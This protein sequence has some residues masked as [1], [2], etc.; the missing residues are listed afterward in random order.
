MRVYDAL[1]GQLGRDW[2]V[3]YHVAW[4]GRVRDDALPRDGEA[5]FVVGHPEL[6]ILV[7]EVKG[8]G[9]RYD[10]ATGQWSSRDGD[11]IIHSIKDPF[12]QATT[13][14]HV[15]KR[16]VESLPDADFGPLKFG[17]A[18]FFP[19]LSREQ[20]AVAEWPAVA[21]CEVILTRDALDQVATGLRQVFAYWGAPAR[22]FAGRALLEELQRMLAPVTELPNPLRL[23]VQDQEQEILRLTE[24]QFSALHWLSYTYRA[25]LFGCAGSGKTMLAVEKARRLAREGLRTLLTCRSGMIAAWLEELTAPQRMGTGRLD[26]CSFEQLCERLARAAGVPLTPAASGP[27]GDAARYHAYPEA[28]ERAVLARPDLRYDAILVD[29]GQDFADLWW[30]ALEKCLREREDGVFYVFHDD[31]QKVYTNAATVPGGLHPFPLTENV[32]NTRTIHRRLVPYYQGEKPSM[33]VGPAGRAVETHAC[34]DRATLRQTLGET[35]D[36]LILVEGIAPRDVV[37]LTPR[38][39]DESDVPGIVS[40]RQLRVVAGAARGATE[41]PCFNVADFK[42]LERPVI[43]VAELGPDLAADAARWI[44]TCYV[45]FS[46]AR[47]YLVIL[48]HPEALAQLPTS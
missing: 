15:L 27:A 28:L 16:K 32:R 48:G 45:A 21:E 18:V 13:S 38:P 22:G 39:L 42:G 4:L 30:L 33:P 41:I 9:I 17:H 37:V 3:F 2:V 44:A 7:I 6:G 25:R 19:D 8:G 43:L 29:E 5:D 35:L 1:K 31:N 11:G 36:R 24:Q 40:T 14:K 46:R 26:V 12:D 47:S 23:Q 10:G 20:V 34:P